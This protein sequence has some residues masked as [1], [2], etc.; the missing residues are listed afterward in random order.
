[1]LRSEHSV[2]VGFLP[3]S[4]Y[5]DVAVPTEDWSSLS[6]HIVSRKNVQ[7]LAYRKLA[8]SIA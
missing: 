5:Y 1:M 7:G 8:R 2:R 3:E 6:K 4:G